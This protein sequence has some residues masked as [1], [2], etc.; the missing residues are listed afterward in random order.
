MKC[1]LLRDQ[2]LLNPMFS[3]RD[4]KLAEESGL[5]YEV[6]RTFE[7][8][9]GY[10]IEDPQAWIHCCPGD[11]NAP[12]I[13][14]AADDECAEAVRV[15]ME[16]KRPAAIAQIKAQLDNIQFVKNPDDKERLLAMGRAYGL[17][18]SDKPKK[19]AKPAATPET[20]G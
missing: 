4:R 1:R 19:A 5:P 16:E 18:G 20:A 12:P 17:I 6:P 11:L 15:W 3:D 2:I 10:V 8:G 7:V 13:A 14:E 9:A